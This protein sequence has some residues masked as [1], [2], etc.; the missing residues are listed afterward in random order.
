[1]RKLF[2]LPLLAAL[3]A[4]TAL[5]QAGAHSRPARFD[6][7]PGAVLDAA[8]SEVT[9]WFTSDIRRADESFIHVLDAEGTELQT[10][11]VQLSSDRRQMSTAL[12]PGLDDGRY[13]VYWSTFDDADGEVFAG[14]YA[15]FVG[16]AAADAAVEEGAALDAAAECPATTE[17][18]HSHDGGESTAS[19]S[20][21]IP[22]VVEGDT[23]TLEI[24]PTDFTPRAPDG[25]TVDPHFGHYHIWLDKVPVEVLTGHSH[26]EGE[27]HADGATGST[28]AMDQ[29]EDD[30]AAEE[31]PGGL[32]ENPVMTFQN[33]FTFTN[34]EPGWHTVAV[35]LTYDDHTLID[36]PVMAAQTFRVEGD[37]GSDGI[38]VWALILGVLAG[39]FAG[40]AG[41]ELL[42]SRA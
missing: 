19:V 38:P 39:L 9:G 29:H 33:S 3:A 30:M 40:G 24:M 13:V 14:C 2:L 27:D 1:L 35:A 42:G 5:S 4:L 10:G 37:D 15:F 16:Q 36:P 7:A 21:S 25:S 6:P 8:P 41:M 17:E 18:D 32:A 12:Q 11:E 20:I 28:G 31:L 26:E 23:A 34:L 22:E